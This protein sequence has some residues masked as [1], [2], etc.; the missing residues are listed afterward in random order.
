MPTPDFDDSGLA[1]VCA[2]R[3]HVLANPFSRP[4]LS[5][6]VQVQSGRVCARTERT[7]WQGLSTTIRLTPDF[8]QFR[9]QSL[10]VALDSLRRMPVAE[11]G[12][13]AL[14]SRH[15][16][17]ALGED[18]CYGR[19]GAGSYTTGTY[20]YTCSGSR[21]CFEP[22]HWTG[23]HQLLTVHVEQLAGQKVQFCQCFV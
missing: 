19:W 23:T 14:V 3:L 12:D 13:I 21:P 9:F 2:T 16:T 18:I 15:L 5:S 6:P 20:G 22:G 1:K 17:Y 8:D 7:I 4:R 10:N 11:R